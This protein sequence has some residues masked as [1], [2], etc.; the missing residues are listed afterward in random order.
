MKYNQGGSKM[1]RK[2]KCR[3]CKKEINTDISFQNI[4]DD[5]RLAHF[6]NKEHYYALDKKI[7]DIREYR[8]MI[9]DLLDEEDVLPSMSNN[10]LFLKELKD[11]AT[12]YEYDLIYSTLT[13]YL[14]DIDLY[15]ADYSE[16]R[17]KIIAFF[18]QLKKYCAEEKEIERQNK[19][20][21]LIMGDREI[22]MVDNIKFKKKKKKIRDMSYI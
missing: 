2:C 20:A 4:L 19:F 21:D 12:M 8:K 5:G 18:N 6:C 15:I 14:T 16:Y 13:H 11:I 10:K 17:N 22:E 3:F 9:L 7:K 1:A